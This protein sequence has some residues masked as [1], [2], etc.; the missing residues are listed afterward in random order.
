M[1]ISYTMAPGRGDTD[2]ILFQLAQRLMQAGFTPCGTVQINTERQDGGKCDM[3]VQVLPRGPV[4]RISQSLGRNARGCRLDPAALETSVAMTEKAL[5]RDAD[6]LI[7]NKFGKHEAE[8]RGF[9]NAIGIALE[10]DLPVLV[11]I[12]PLNRQA[13][14]DFVGDLG[15]AL[16]PEIDRLE[17]WAKAQL[18]KGEERGEPLLR[19]QSAA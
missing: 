11:G 10:R 19:A 16:P 14:L 7:I 12:N 6:L 8:G 5:Q 17:D 15:C 3:D 4:I 13:F 2:L 1:Q 9:R 18:T